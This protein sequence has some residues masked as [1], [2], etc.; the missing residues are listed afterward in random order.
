M[1]RPGMRNKGSGGRGGGSFAV[2]W[3]LAVDYPHQHLLLTT[4]DQR[5]LCS[6][7]GHLAGAAH[8]ALFLPSDGK[9]L[10]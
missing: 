1:R 2:E 6:Q 4:C 9:R 3:L 7:S 8:K 5:H 10:S